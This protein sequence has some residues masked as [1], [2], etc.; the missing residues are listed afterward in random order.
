[1]DPACSGDHSRD[2]SLLDTTT[3]V[4]LPIPPVLEFS[5]VLEQR[6]ALTPKLSITAYV[7]AIAI[8]AHFMR[9][10]DV[11]NEICMPCNVEAL[12]LDVAALTT[13]CC[14]NV[15]SLGR[16]PRCAS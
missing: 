12:D 11:K 5:C 6:L 14:S 16:E 8:S 10:G 13:P 1:M 3:G 9:D 4:C 7:D 2:E 15:P